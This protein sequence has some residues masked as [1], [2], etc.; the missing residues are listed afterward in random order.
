MSADAAFRRFIEVLL[1]RGGSVVA[2]TEVYV[3]ESYDDER[4]TVLCI[5]GYVFR[6]RKALEFSK[7]W[8]GFLERNG[9]PYFHMSECAHGT[10]VFEGKD[11]D[12]IARKLIKQ[13]RDKTEYGF[14]ISIN[15]EDFNELVGPQEGIQSAYAFLLLGCMHQVLRW[16]RQSNIVGPTAFFF[17]QGHAHQKDANAFINWIVEHNLYRSMMEYS[18]HAFVPKATTGLHPADNLAWHWRLESR[19][20]LDPNRIKMRKDFLALLRPG[21]DT[22]HDYSRPV[23]MRLAEDLERRQ[24]DREATIRQFLEGD[25]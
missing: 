18:G 17:E 9:L 16:K 13:T 14:A 5:A 22:L 1:P 2:L 8:G 24:A 19:R 25:S 12:T 20:R 11:C 10:G 3:D 6:R 21:L 23:L 7:S 15:V 4:P